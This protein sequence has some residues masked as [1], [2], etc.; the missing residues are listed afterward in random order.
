MASLRLTFQKKAHENV[1]QIPRSVALQALL[2]CDQ[3]EAEIEQGE[4]DLVVGKMRE[5]FQGWL[6]EFDNIDALVAIRAIRALANEV[7]NEEE[8]TD[9]Q[10]GH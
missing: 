10:D 9:G 8:A 4:P 5:K 6:D 1:V 7:L 2:Y 3:F